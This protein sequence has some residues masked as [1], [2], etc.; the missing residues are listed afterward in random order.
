MFNY[1]INVAIK[2]KKNGVFQHYCKIV[3]PNGATKTQAIEMT[4]EYRN[5]FPDRLVN[6]YECP[7]K[8]LR[9][10]PV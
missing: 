2:S 6:L 5:S 1:E 4:R 10:I 3:L 9:T 8:T 7:V